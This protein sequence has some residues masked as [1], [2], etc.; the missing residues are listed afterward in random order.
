MMS[1]LF[2]TRVEEAAILS[3][4]AVAGT[5]AKVPGCHGGSTWP[6]HAMHLGGAGVLYT[7]QG[8]DKERRFVFDD[9]FEVS[10]NVMHRNSDW[11]DASTPD[12]VDD[13]ATSTTL[14]IVAFDIWKGLMTAHGVGLLA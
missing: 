3:L 7:W 5:A 11:M 8:I 9:D 14:D 13:H 10:Q 1:R 12:V 6:A 4:R 2:S